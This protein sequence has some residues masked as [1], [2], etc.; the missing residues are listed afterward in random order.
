MSVLTCG[1]IARR[2]Q[3][4]AH[5][6]DWILRTRGVEPIGRAGCIRIYDEGTVAYVKGEIER[7]DR[8]HR[9]LGRVA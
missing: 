9:G 3:V 6:V 4:P 5:R 7:Q 8:E 2:L 1:E